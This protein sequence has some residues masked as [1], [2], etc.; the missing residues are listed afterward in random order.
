[1]PTL[2]PNLG[3]PKIIAASEE[4]KNA[5]LMREIRSGEKFRRA[6]GL[7]TREHEAAAEAQRMRGHKTLK[8]GGSGLG[9]CVFT[10]SQKDFFHVGEKVSP[11]DMSAPWQDRE[12]LQYLQKKFP[13]LSP[14]KV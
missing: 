2:S 11:K 3:S 9:K 8:A 5:A 4:A 1:M 7:R 14:N 12:F 13:H 10:M 6:L